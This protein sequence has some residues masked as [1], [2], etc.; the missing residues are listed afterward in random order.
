M[1]SSPASFVLLFTASPD[2]PQESADPD[3]LFDLGCCVGKLGAGRVIVLHRGG[4][5][6]TDR[7]GL[8]HVVFDNFEGWRLQ[9]A[10]HLK[11]G[12]VEVDLNKLI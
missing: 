11:R 1:Q 3:A 12:G 10:R 7:F 6:H 8:T 2:Q 4:E 9:L 5:A